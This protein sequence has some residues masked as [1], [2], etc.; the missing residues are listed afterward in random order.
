MISHTVFQA[1]FFWR[2]L[3]RA[4]QG[5]G[6]GKPVAAFTKKSFCAVAGPTVATPSVATRLTCEQAQLSR[7]VYHV[8]NF[9][10]GESATNNE[11]ERLSRRWKQ[12]RIGLFDGG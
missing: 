10:M 1:R 11:L 12:T 3:G 4:A 6:S 9:A 7:L 2:R 5:A 8:S